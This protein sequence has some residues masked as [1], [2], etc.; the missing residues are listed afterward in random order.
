MSIQTEED[1]ASIALPERT[2]LGVIEVVMVIVVLAVLAGF[3][4]P[5]VVAVRASTPSIATAA[6]GAD[7]RVAVARTHAIWLAES[8]PQ[9]LRID[10]QLVRFA[11][12]YPDLGS[13]AAVL[14]SVEGFAY[15]DSGGVFSRLDD[16]DA[17][18][19]DCGVSYE[20]PGAR[21]E[22]PQIAVVT[23]GC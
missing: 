16:E 7:L 22:A 10:D 13:V 1:K 12:G 20:P 17:A 9:E 19:P 6:L 8:Q 5:R 21:G 14:E 18:M 11:F 4:V 2:G 23:E 15:D 3:A